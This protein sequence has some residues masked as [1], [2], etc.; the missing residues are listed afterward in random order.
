MEKQEEQEKEIK[1][2]YNKL[3]EVYG[4]MVTTY[5]RKVKKDG[6]E[7]WTDC[8]RPAFRIGKDGI[9]SALYNV[10]L[11]IEKYRK[12]EIKHLNKSIGKRMEVLVE[13][14]IANTATVEEIKKLSESYTNIVWYHN[15]QKTA[16]Q[17]T[18]KKKVDVKDNNYFQTKFR[19]LEEEMKEIRGWDGVIE[20]LEKLMKDAREQ[21]QYH[22]DQI[23]GKGM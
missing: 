6:K 4:S 17:K 19:K 22:L 9:C 12:G 13:K 21:R 8:K 7:I 18:D 11:Y 20:T 14:T 5:H 3:V 2:I 1:A 10:S 15:T 23:Y 16:E